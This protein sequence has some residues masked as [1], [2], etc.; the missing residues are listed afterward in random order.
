MLNSK[1]VISLKKMCNN[2]YEGYLNEKKRKVYSR[3]KSS[4]ERRTCSYVLL[5]YKYY[6]TIKVGDCVC[7]AI[8]NGTGMD[9]K[10]VYDLING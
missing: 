9:Y 5:H 8:A 6:N 7:R 10:E 1:S 3:R 2:Y 4:V